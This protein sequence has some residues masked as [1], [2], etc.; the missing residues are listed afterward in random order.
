VALVR[1]GSTITIYVNGNSSGT[2]TSTANFSDT[3]TGIGIALTYTPTSQFFGYISNFR[4]LKGTAL[5]T[6]NFTPST[7]PLTAIS[8]TSL[9]TCQSNRFIDNSAN[10]FAITVSGDTRISGFI[11]FTPN[12]SYTT[13]GS[14]YFDGSGDYVSISSGMNVASNDFTIETWIFP[15]AWTSEYGSIFSTRPSENTVGATDV[16]VLGVHNTGYPYVYSGAFQIQGSAGQIVLNRWTHLAVTRSGSTMRLFVNGV[17]V[18]TSTSLQNYTVSTAAIGANTNGS[19]PFT[20]LLADLR[21]VVGTAVYTSSFTPPVEPLTAV[22]NTRLLTL[23]TNQSPDNS[24]FIDSSGRNFAVT[25]VGN[26]TQG[27]FSPYGNFWSN[28]FDGTGDYLNTATL[29]SVGSG[30][31]TIEFWLYYTGGNGYTAFVVTQGGSPQIYYGLNTGGLNPFVWNGSSAQLTTST[32]ITKNTWQ[33]HALVRISGNIT[34]YLD[35]TAIGTTSYS[36]SITTGIVAIGHNGSNIQNVTGY[37]SNLRFI[38]GTAIYTSNFT[39]PTSPLTAV[40]ETN[41]LTCQSNRFIDN[42][43]NNFTITRVGNTRVTKFS[44]FKPSVGYSTATNGGSSYFDG[45]D[46]VLITATDAATFGT[47]DYTVELWLNLSSNTQGYPHVF[48]LSTADTNAGSPMAIFFLDSQNNS[49]Q[50]FIFVIKLGSDNYITG[51]TQNNFYNTWRHIA[52]SRTGTSAR[53]FIDG[54]LVTTLTDSVNY[55]GAYRIRSG[56]FINENGTF[57]MAGYTSDIRVIKGTALYTSNFTPPA[58]PVA[59]TAETTL[60]LSYTGSGVV[61]ETGQNNLETVGNARISTTVKKY[62]TGSMYFDGT[63]DNLLIP[64]SP[65]LV[66]RSDFTIELWFYAVAKNNMIL[67]FGG[68]TG[69]AWASY[70]LVNNAD[71]VNFA[72]SSANSGYDI[73]SELGTTGRIGT[74]ELNTWNH[75]AVTRSGNVYRGFVNGIQ[76]Y[77]QTLSLTPYDTG[78]RGLAIGSNYATT[79]GTGTPTSVINGYIDDLR[80]TQGVARYTANFTPP[81]R[82]PGK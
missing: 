53:V 38:V 54:V 67:N 68:G 73:G 55:S 24:R 50:A 9:L 1:S 39:P 51:Y 33:H 21:L 41:L 71:G 4:I 57:S 35:G 30:D 44:P 27:S 32:S 82:L 61:D 76:G 12:I 78:S 64:Y 49:P 5:Y 81:A 7:T 28:Y 60:L 80:I 19:Q 72:A 17:L 46:G 63:G 62:G 37:M 79:W 29:P 70:E 26:V 59:R 75:L 10:N 43:T 66:L 8:G 15:T 22:T 25:R 42:S 31:F 58:A 65:A 20:G 56:Y 40:S 77:T 2:F 45:G 74:I 23:A 16:W 34:I 6:T 14:G 48:N 11:P 13:Q 69:I 52:I 36:N 18:Q 47:G 3:N